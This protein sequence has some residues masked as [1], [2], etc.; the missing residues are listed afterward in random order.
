[1]A[2]RTLVVVAYDISDDKRRARVAQMLLSYGA[3]VEASVYELWL[4]GREI[5]KM[6]HDLSRTVK[7]SDLVRC[8]SVCERC[9]GRVRSNCLSKPQDDVAFFA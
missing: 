2:D 1:M 9:V 3:R 7:E 8:Y 4:T 5:E 6:W